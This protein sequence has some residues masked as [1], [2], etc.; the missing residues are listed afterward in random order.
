MGQHTWLLLATILSELLVII[1]WSQ[2]LFP[3]PMPGKVKLFLSI[4]GFL[5]VAYPTVHVSKQSFVNID[6]DT[7]LFLVWRPRGQ[8]ISPTA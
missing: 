4:L 6:A 3:E 5:L 2:G 1:K 7:E 8:E